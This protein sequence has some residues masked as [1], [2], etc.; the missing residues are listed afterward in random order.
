MYI[1]GKYE[2]EFNIC[3]NNNL[4]LRKFELEFDMCKNF[5]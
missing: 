5:F 1:Y 3:K 4:N 2:P